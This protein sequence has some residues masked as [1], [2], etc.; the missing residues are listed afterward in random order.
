MT[1]LWD[2]SNPLNV[3]HTDCGVV[4]SIQELPPHKLKQKKTDNKQHKI[5]LIPLTALSKLIQ[6][7]IH[8]I[9]RRA[10]PVQ[11]AE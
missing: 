1:L 10:I 3:C 11:Q 8:N 7:I 2:D 4:G 9:G 6:I 5:Y